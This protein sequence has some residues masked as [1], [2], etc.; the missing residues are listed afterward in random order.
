M[1]RILMVEDDALVG[2]SL[3]RLLGSRY[4]VTV[5]HSVDQALELLHMEEFDLIVSDVVM[6]HK[7][8]MDLHAALEKRGVA[9][10][11]VFLTGAM[12]SQ[13]VK[14]FLA[15]VP[16]RYLEKPSTREALIEL[17]EGELAKLKR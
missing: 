8:G 2:R 9:N 13:N 12:L 16:N 3:S 7:S 4:D 14:D 11:I 6:P 17:I 15:R 10:T 1:A 5:V